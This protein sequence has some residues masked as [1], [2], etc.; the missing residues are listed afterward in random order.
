MCV[1]VFRGR[2]FLFLLLSSMY[3]NVELELAQ[4]ETSGF[5]FGTKEKNSLSGPLLHSLTVAV[6][7]CYPVCECV[8]VNKLC[9]CV[10]V[11]GN[12]NAAVGKRLSIHTNTHKCQ[13]KF[14][15]WFNHWSK[16]ESFRS[17]KHTDTHNRTQQTRPHSHDCNCMYM[18][19]G[20]W[21]YAT[22][23]AIALKVLWHYSQAMWFIV[24]AR[25]LLPAWLD[26]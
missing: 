22:L 1:Y 6:S 15:Q 21:M 5:L 10:W 4:L 20:P 16:S 19:S 17:L 9:V 7:V 8:S 14:G 11:D 26:F 3:G 2:G 13:P 23:R 18:Y 12:N 24:L 25:P